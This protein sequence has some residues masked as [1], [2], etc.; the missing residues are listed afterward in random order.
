MRG[1]LAV[2]AVTAAAWSLSLTPAISGFLYLIAIVLSAVDGDFP[3][4]AIVSVIAAACLD[5]FLTPP[6]LNFRITDPFDGVMLVAFLLT[7]LVV[8]RLGSTARQQT[9]IAQIER[10]RTEQIQQVTERLLSMRPE[11][12]AGEGILVPF[13]EVLGLRAACL[14]EGETAQM[15][16][17][18]QSSHALAARTRDAFI[19]NADRD[20][21]EEGLA[22][23]CF[24]TANH[25]TGAIG[26]EG[27]D[28]PAMTGPLTAVAASCLDRMRAF[29]AAS[30][31]AAQ[32]HAETLRGAVLDALAHEFKTPL[33]VILTA[34]GGLREVGPLAPAQEELADL[35][36][37][38]ASRLGSLT[39]RLLRIGQ[40]DRENLKLSLVELDLA[41]LVEVAVKR[42]S[43]LWPEHRFTIARD[44]LPIEVAAD[45]DL[46]RLAL[47]QLVE[48]ACKY[49]PAGSTVELRLATQD[50]IASVTVW[51][52]SGPIETEARRKVF[53]R[54][55]RAD[56]EL[57]NGTGLGLYVARRVA[58]AHSGQLVLEPNDRARGGT[59]FRFVLPALQRG[60]A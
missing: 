6:V 3:E 39:S 28:D 30:Q 18:G 34:A 10:R 25:A 46:L 29:E 36:E 12:A 2:A 35:V 33:A 42:Y 9:W 41:A 54:F 32:A 55:Y 48:N 59:A 56:E 11:A 7:S 38:E 21:K 31:A 27:L 53:E 1:V 51:S 14:F 26:F 5:Y 50:A 44:R 58:V 45:S 49:S 4:A 47:N 57:S 15:Y 40:L 13:V 17:R 24:R 43:E 16:T 22:I 19:H 52:S 20:E 37:T 60:S 8:T 23:R